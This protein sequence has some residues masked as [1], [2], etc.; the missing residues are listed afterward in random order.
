[1][2]WWLNSKQAVKAMVENRCVEETEKA[3]AALLEGDSVSLTADTW[4]SINMDV[5]LASISV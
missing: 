5:Y 2:H 3:K 1:M 4:T